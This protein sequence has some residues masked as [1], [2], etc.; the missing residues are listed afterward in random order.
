MTDLLGATPA[1]TSAAQ[2]T[3]LHNLRRRAR[4]QFIGAV[5]LVLLAVIAIP[6]VLDGKPRP[7]SPNIVIEV[8]SVIPSPVAAPAPVT[9][10][11]EPAAAASSPIAAP[12]P[13]PPA[14]TIAATPAPAT[15]AAP[16]PSPAPPSPAPAAPLKAVDVAAILNG[17][18]STTATTTVSTPSTS[19]YLLQVGSYADKTKAIAMQ[20][21]LDKAGLTNFAQEATA[22]DGTTHTRVRLGPYATQEETNAASSRVAKMGIKSI[23]IKP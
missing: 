22:K 23:V 2:N 21:K 3:E 4:Q 19:G 5:V 12:A 8:A 20:A 14:D 1:P 15:P 11:P 13:I 7:I 16:T 17:T 6:F 10:T 18:A 9:A